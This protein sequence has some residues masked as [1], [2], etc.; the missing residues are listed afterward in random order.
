MTRTRR[1]PLAPLRG[2]RTVRQL[3]A[4]IGAHPKQIYRWADYG[5]DPWQ[6]DR[7]ACAL[8]LHPQIVWPDYDEVMT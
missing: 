2:H 6:A 7:A 5:L 3:A 4:E 8:G 1:F